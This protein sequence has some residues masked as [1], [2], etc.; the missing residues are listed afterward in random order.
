M[1]IIL[2]WSLIIGSVYVGGAQTAV[3]T[4]QL[5]KAEEAFD[6]GRLLDVLEILDK[7]T[8]TSRDCFVFFS[9]TQKIQAEKLLTKTYIFAD[10]VPAAENSLV[11][12]LREENEHQLT[13]NDPSELHFLYSQFKTEPAFR[14]GMRVSLNKSL[15]VVLQSFNSFQ[16]GEKKY[17]QQGE[18]TNLGIGLSCE[19]LVEKHL[20][21][22]I[23]VG[24]GPQLRLASYEVEGNLLEKQNL[25]FYKVK[26]QS[27]MLRL[28]LLVRYNLN[29]DEKNSE[30]VRISSL[31]YAFLGV[32][33][34]YV[35][36]ANYVVTSRTGGTAFSLNANNS[37]TKFDQ[38][39]RTNTSIFGGVGIKLRTGRAQV[40]FLTF[41]VRYNNA[42]FN[43]INPANRFVNKDINFDI[44]HVEDDLILNTISISAGYTFSVYNLKKRKQYR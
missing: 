8:G 1:K 22:G 36:A 15:P 27:T 29:Y 41:E 31:P 5:V 32:S 37:L 26:N 18:E 25:L 11:D 9:K 3:C 24:I 4:Q 34:D 44:G 33:F 7:S 42:L 28:P 30:E 39:A 14:I 16:V 40:N 6:Q 20:A 43:Y 35:I 19:A 12:L 17:N 23:E 38:V 21:K 10:N 13:K 2:A